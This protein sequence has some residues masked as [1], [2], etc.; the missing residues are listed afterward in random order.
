MAIRPMRTALLALGLTGAAASCDPPDN[1]VWPVTAPPTCLDV[2]EDGFGAG[3]ELGADCDDGTPLLVDEC[4]LCDTE[5]RPGCRC[6]SGEDPVEQYYS[7]PEGTIGHGACEA[8]VR[9]CVSDRWA[10]VEPDRP[11]N[12]GEICGN[13]IDDDCDDQVDENA[14]E[15]PDCDPSCHTGGGGDGLWNDDPADR[16]G[17]VDTD[18]GGL[19]LREDRER[20]GFAWIAN[21]G[22]ATVSKIDTTSGDEVARYRTGL[23]D[24]TANR[25]SRTAVDRQGDVYVAN[26]AFGEQGSVTKIAGLAEGCV[27]RDLDDAIATSTGGADVLD[28]DEDECVLW[29]VPLSGVDAVPRSLAVDAGDDEHPAGT[30]WIGTFNDREEDSE[31]H[32]RAFRLDPADGSVLASIALPVQPYGAIADGEGRVWFTAWGPEALAYVTIADGQASG[33]IVKDEPYG[34]NQTYGIAIDALGR[35]WTGGWTCECAYRY[36]PTDGSWT[37]IDLR[38]RGTTRGLGPDAEGNMWIAHYTDPGALT[39]VPIDAAGPVVAQTDTELVPLGPEARGTVG[40]GAD[41][42]GHLW[43]VNRDS[44]N[45]TRLDLDDRTQDE[46]PTGLTPYTYSDFTGFQLRAQVV[47]EGSY[48]QDFTGCDP[49]PNPDDPLLTAWGDLTWDAVVPDATSLEIS[50]R[51]ATTE[52]GLAAAQEVVVATIPDDAPPVD[53]GAALEAAGITPAQ[54]LRVT[55]RFFSEDRVARPV[56]YELGLTWICPD[57]IG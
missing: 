16:E 18:D 47:P 13:E 46:H 54:F 51:T 15:C 10:V 3:C 43:V 7:G 21:D 14:F 49:G 25:P 4:D 41:F 5:H 27:D 12:A 55:V 33:A 6:R 2:D 38:G 32:G 1:L 22:E 11:P 39:R 8:G 36:D 28:Y 52:A 35:I 9:G 31:R 26:R 17:I 23:A 34:C 53:T 50:I 57:V 44:S 45:V 30:P 20:F 37:T 56:L 19:T 29:T 42:S 40:V 48:S 24:V